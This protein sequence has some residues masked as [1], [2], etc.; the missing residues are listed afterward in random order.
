KT[1]FWDMVAGAGPR[2][3]PTF[4]GGQIYTLG[5]TGILNSLDAA[6]GRLNW[7]RNIVNDSAAPL[8]MWGFSSSPLVADEMVIVYAGG[9][10]KKGLLAYQADSGKLAWT[11]KV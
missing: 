11:A 4:D 6:S 7:T 9:T 10:E 2:A 8:P 1:R 3:T 5:A